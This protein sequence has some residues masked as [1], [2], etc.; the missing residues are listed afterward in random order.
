VHPSRKSSCTDLTGVTG[1]YN[2]AGDYRR[3]P[4]SSFKPY[5][6]IAALQQ[7]ISLDSRF[8]GPSH[9]DFPGTGGKGISNSEGESCGD[10][11]LTEAL[12]KSINTIF[13]PLAERVGPDKVAQAAKD[14]GI[15]ARRIP[16][17][18]EVP[19]ITLGTS[20]VAPIDQ[21]VGYATIAAQG[22]Y[23]KPYLVATVK[24][25]SGRRVFQAKKDAHRALPADVM[26]DT[27][28][29]MTQVLTNGTAAGKGLSGRPAAGK[30]GTNGER[31]GDR[32][33]WFIGFTPQLSTAVWYGNADP[34]KFVTDN[35]AALYGGGL[36]ALTWQQMMNAALQGEPVESFPPA[37]HVGSAINPAPSSSSTNSASSSPSPSAT[38]TPTVSPTPTVTATKTP[39]GHSS[40]PT[41]SP[42]SSPT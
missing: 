11:T 4:G 1:L 23:T 5:T 21:A 3:S 38:S 9:I 19:A 2:P 13:V 41:S 17:E 8:P 27:T 6:L 33:A 26:A 36:P 16:P 7:G 18:D 15:P 24:T 40:S 12:A 22:V 30:T 14:A 32:D 39:P 34:K 20:A 35:G 25:S 28:Y 42:S 37:A 10:C 29:A 31:N